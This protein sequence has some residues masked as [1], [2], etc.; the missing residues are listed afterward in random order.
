MVVFRRQ[1]MTKFKVIFY[2]FFVFISFNNK[3][4]KLYY[5]HL[6]IISEIQSILRGLYYFNKI[7][8]SMRSDLITLYI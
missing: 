4:I 1:K 5:A 6:V 7:C 2:L 8:F 3:D